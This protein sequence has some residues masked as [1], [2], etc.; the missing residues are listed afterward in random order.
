MGDR[1][2]IEPVQHHVCTGIKRHRHHKTAGYSYCPFPHADNCKQ[3]GKKWQ[4]G[5]L[6]DDIRSF[7]FGARP[8]SGV[9][10][11]E[12]PWRRVAL[13]GP[14][15]R[16]RRRPTAITTAKYGLR[17]FVMAHKW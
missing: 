15:A 1:A 2:R 12:K 10:P 9:Q 13:F 16:R 7:G 3:F 6:R 11:N 4:S 8:Y 14:P 17:P 5:F